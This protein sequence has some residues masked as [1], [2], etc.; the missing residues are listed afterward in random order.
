MVTYDRSQ[1]NGL[2]AP[3]GSSYIVLSP[4]T[5]PHFIY[6]LVD[7]YFV[8]EG[9]E[10]GTRLKRVSKFKVILHILWILEDHLLPPMGLCIIK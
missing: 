10:K 1:L 4:E 8:E 5:Q 2:R 6:Q 9:G 7:V 3:P